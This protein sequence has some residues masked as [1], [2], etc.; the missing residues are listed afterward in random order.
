MRTAS[1]PSLMARALSA[2]SIL[3]GHGAERETQGNIHGSGL[4][5]A[6]R[7]AAG[8]SG[9]MAGRAPAARSLSP[10]LAFRELRSR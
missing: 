4:G 8:R 3:R 6:V 10:P 2:V 9:P 1:A 5:P 7:A